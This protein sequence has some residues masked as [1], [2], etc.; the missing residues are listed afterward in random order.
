MA[1][2]PDGCDDVTLRRVDDDR[3]IDRSCGIVA[4]APLP[5]V[6]RLPFVR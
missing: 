3:S 1:M 4:I 2:V 5:I 6:R